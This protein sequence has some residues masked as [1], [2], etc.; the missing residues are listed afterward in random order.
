[1]T[2]VEREIGAK[3]RDA[4]VS[5]GWSSANLQARMADAGC[6]VHLDRIETGATPLTVS[7]LSVLSMVLGV[8]AFEILADRAREPAPEVIRARLA[9]GSPFEDAQSW[10]RAHPRSGGRDG[11]RLGVR[12]FDRDSD[13]GWMV[14]V[15]TEGTSLA[16]RELSDVEHEPTEDEWLVA[17]VEGDLFSCF[18]WPGGLGDAFA[19]FCQWVRD[20]DGEP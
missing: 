20:N 10:D 14:R 17:W 19:V 16:N 3:V 7:T 1:M 18:C 4:R 13:A 9:G 6:R 12:A 8:K 11:S 15:D 2:D 5:A